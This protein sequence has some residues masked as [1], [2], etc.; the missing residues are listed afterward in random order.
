MDIEVKSFREKICQQYNQVGINIPQEEIFLYANEQFWNALFQYTKRDYTALKKILDSYSHP[1]IEE[2]KEYNKNPTNKITD[3]H[4]FHYDDKIMGLYPK[5][6]TVYENL[7]NMISCYEKEKKKH[8]HKGLIFY[9]LGEHYLIND[10]TEK[11]LLFINK[12]F[13]E[14]DMKHTDISQNFPDSPAYKF[15]ILNI[16]DPNQALKYIVEKIGGFIKNNFLDDFGYSYGDFFNKFLNAASNVSPLER[17]H[18]WLDHVIFFN[19][20]MFKLEKSYRMSEEILNSIFG[21]IILSSLIGDLCLQ[22]ESFCKNKL[23]INGMFGSIYNTLKT[24]GQNIYNWSGGNI[25]SSDFRNSALET[26][27]NDIYRNSYQSNDAL[28][29]SFYLSWG[30]RNNFHHNIESMSIIRKHFKK[31]IKKQLHFFFDFTI[32]R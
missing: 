1:G 24:T 7:L 5:H 30:L 21:E 26:T 8:V 15:M 31:I 14:D 6:I 2:V 23:R 18:K 19:N 32:N 13:R 3:S 27:L 4:Y 25:I 9:F 29:N 28:E 11:G 12:A 20:I 17:A 10:Y 16:E 22:I